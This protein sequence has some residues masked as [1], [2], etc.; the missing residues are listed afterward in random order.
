MRCEVRGVMGGKVRLSEGVSGLI[1]V[2]G[3]LS[4]RTAQAKAAAT[5]ALRAGNRGGAHRRETLLCQLLLQACVRLGPRYGGWSTTHSSTCRGRSK[6][7]HELLLLL[8]YHLSTAAAA[9][10]PQELALHPTYL[11]I[12]LLLLLLVMCSLRHPTAGCRGE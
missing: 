3:R 9:I 1:A 4:V 12:R 5:A 7:A 11:L 8:L 2:L 6:W 10:V